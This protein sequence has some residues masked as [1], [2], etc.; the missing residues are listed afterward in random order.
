MN[1]SRFDTP[2]FQLDCGYDSIS[3]QPIPNSLVLRHFHSYNNIQN[4]RQLRKR[5]S[6]QVLFYYRKTYALICN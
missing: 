1:T 6:Y 5:T 4:L 3:R 2:F